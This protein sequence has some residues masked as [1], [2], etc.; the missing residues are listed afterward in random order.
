MRGNR[1]SIFIFR[2]DSPNEWFSS[3]GVGMSFENSTITSLFNLMH[4]ELLSQKRFNLKFNDAI[5]LDNYTL[6]TKH[7]IDKIKLSAI[8]QHIMMGSDRRVLLL[9]DHW[10]CIIF[11]LN[12]QFKY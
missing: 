10:S 8:P 12:L 6:I 7:L 2:L 3:L 4:L 1:L 9:I 11:Q 5:F